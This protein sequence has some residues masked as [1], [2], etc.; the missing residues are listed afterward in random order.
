VAGLRSADGEGPEMVCDPR[1]CVFVCC[2]AGRLIN[3]FGALR[4]LG[5]RGNIGLA[6]PL[7]DGVTGLLAVGLSVWKEAMDKRRSQLVDGRR[8]WSV[9][10]SVDSF[11]G[12]CS[13]GAVNV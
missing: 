7:N 10:E 13:G 1:G 12:I 3:L 9:C 5:G 4:R 6:D 2:D 8:A 11:S